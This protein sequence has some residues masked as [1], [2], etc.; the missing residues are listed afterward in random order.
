MECFICNIFFNEWK[1]LLRHLSS[2]HFLERKEVYPCKYGSC[3]HIF[4][5]LYEYGRHFKLHL[6]KAAHSKSGV[7]NAN[8]VF[9]SD[10]LVLNENCNNI[11]VP[12]QFNENNFSSIPNEIESLSNNSSNNIIAHSTSRDDFCCKHD[13]SIVFLLEMHAKSNFSRSDVAF[14][15]Q[16]VD[17]SVQ[18]IVKSFTEFTNECDLDSARRIRLATI[19]HQCLGESSHD[20]YSENHLFNLLKEKGYLHDV[21]QFT[22]N[23]EISEVFSNGEMTYGEN[24][25]K[26]SLLPISFQIK[27]FFEHNGR[28][29]VALEKIEENLLIVDMVNSFTVNCGNRKVKY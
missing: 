7:N 1:P 10:E 14:V 17:A 12:F 19:L 2:N 11:P 20:A 28:L 3:E 26:A 8:A 5:D 18:S 6:A 21:K 4:S 9:P 13:D 22:V 25:A 16:R 24:K 27:M 29:S 23:N 15:Q